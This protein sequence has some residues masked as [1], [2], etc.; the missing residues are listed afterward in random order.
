V[1]TLILSPHFDDAIGSLGGFIQRRVAEARVPTIITITGGIPVEAGDRDYVLLRR[2]ED[3]QAC[4][5]IGCDNAVLPLLDAPYRTSRARELLYP[6]EFAPVHPDDDAVEQTVDHLAPFL[7]TG[8]A[9]LWAPAG[10]G[11]HVDHLVCRAAAE[12][13][14][15][16]AV[17]LI[18]YRDFF[19]HC[20]HPA[21]PQGLVRAATISLTPREIRRKISA[22]AHYR[23]QIQGLYGDSKEMAR[24]FVLFECEE[25]LYRKSALQEAAMS[26][27]AISKPPLPPRSSR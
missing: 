23:S 18:W 22:F 20:D 4:R 26:N 27:A 13:L 25:V 16:Q 19:Y 8:E 6:K 12:R 17:S 10:I 7:A 5:A 14:A 3:V 21:D 11:G 1:R 9:E 24:R 15:N 2:E